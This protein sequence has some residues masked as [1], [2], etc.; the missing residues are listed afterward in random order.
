VKDEGNKGSTGPRPDEG[1]TIASLEPSPASFALEPGAGQHIGKYVVERVLGRGGMGVVVLAR[2]QHLDERVAIKV[3]HAKAATDAVLRERFVR[4]ARS[5]V[6]IKSEHVVRVLDAGVQE[7]SGAPFIVME[8]L[9]GVD[10]G[11]LLERS[12]PMPVTIAVD[13]IIQIC[14][15]VAAA[16]ALGIIHRDLKP[17]N[18]FLTRRADGTAHVKVL[19]FGISKAASEEGMPDPRLTETQ[20]VFGSPTYMSPEQI[21]SSKNV[22]VRS[23]VWSLG[24]ALFELLTG[25]LP[26]VADNVAGLL[27]SVIADPPFRLTTFIAAPD[28]LEAIVLGCLEKDPARRIGSALELAARLTPF[29]SADVAHLTARMDRVARDGPYARSFPPIPLSRSNPPFPP[30]VFESTGTDLSATR[31]AAHRRQSR[32]RRTPIVIGAVTALAVLA[33]G[34]VGAATLLGI[35][36]GA[37]GGGATRAPAAAPPPF[38]PDTAPAPVVSVMPPSSQGASEAAAP[39]SAPAVSAVAAG[40]R[41]KPGHAA[42]TPTVAASSTAG[43]TTPAPPP[44]P[45]APASSTDLDSRF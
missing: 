19:D 34:M 39:A 26:F 8:H 9:D 14:E 36:D 38:V 18:F 7:D 4:E 44:L 13:C 31:P 29:A 10:L 37:G 28:E 42:R 12:G 17:S 21:R 33:G 3:L 40:R 16:H 25:H 20:A 15:A 45:P 6:R 22:N 43:P 41:G 30:I 2:H 23:D 35:R 11:E 1:L 5:T 24:V 32:P 27:A